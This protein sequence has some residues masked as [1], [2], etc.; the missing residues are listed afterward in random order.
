MV[1]NVPQGGKSY[2]NIVVYMLFEQ[3][4]MAIQIPR[5]SF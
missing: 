2:K 3:C 1:G 4:I 5:I